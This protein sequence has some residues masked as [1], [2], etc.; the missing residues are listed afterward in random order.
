[1]VTVIVAV[2]FIVAIN[3]LFV[4]VIKATSGASDRTTASTTAYSNLR[5]YAYAGARPTWFN[6]CASADMQSQANPPGQTLDAGSLSASQIDLPQP[7]TYSIKAFAPYGCSGPNAGSP[8]LIR[9][10]VT[11][12]PDNLTVTHATYVGSE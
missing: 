6:D 4:A 9:S 8:L 12:G 5:K 3:V 2:F 1:M 10:T 7:V 11:Y